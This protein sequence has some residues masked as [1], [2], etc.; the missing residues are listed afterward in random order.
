MRVEICKNTLLL[1]SGV[2]GVYVWKGYPL[3]HDDMLATSLQMST[4]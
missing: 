4:G 1:S 3:I 2:E